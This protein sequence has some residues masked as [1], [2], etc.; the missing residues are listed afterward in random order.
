MFDIPFGFGWVMVSA[1]FFVNLIWVWGMTATPPPRS[2]ARKRAA[3]AV[4]PSPKKFSRRTPLPL[5]PVAPSR[6]SARI[7]QPVP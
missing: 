5:P 2:T 1:Y 6:I 3:R 7:A 4:K